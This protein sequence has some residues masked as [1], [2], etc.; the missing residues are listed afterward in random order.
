MRWP[1]PP[2]RPT[3][4][5]PSS[6]CSVQPADEPYGAVVGVGNVWRAEANGLD[7]AAAVWDLGWLVLVA[8][9]V[10]GAVSA[11]RRRR[12]QWAAGILASLAVS[13]AIGLA[14]TGTHGDQAGVRGLALTPAAMTVSAAG[15]VVTYAWRSAR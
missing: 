9:A 13:V 12:V 3:A 14:A 11:L 7:A 6:T 15:A 2:G 5:T 1:S 10:A 4:T 8:T